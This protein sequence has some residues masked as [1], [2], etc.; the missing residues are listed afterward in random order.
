M[1]KQCYIL[2]LTLLLIS[3][4]AQ[5][6]EKVVS[7]VTLGDYPPFC[8]VDSESQAP[9]MSTLPPGSNVAYF[10]GYSWDVLRESFHIMGYTIQLTVA[11]WPRAIK[12]VEI[13][14]ADILFPTGKNSERLKIFDYSKE[15][16]NEAKFLVYVTKDNP[17]QWNG[18]ESFNNLVIG[19]KRGFNY[20]DKWEAAQKIRRHEVGNIMNGFL[21]LDNK[22]ISGFLGYEFNWDYLLKQ[23]GWHNKYRKLPSFDSSREYLTSLKTNPLGPQLLSDFDKGKQML[24]RN[25]RLEEIQKEWFGSE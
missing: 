8:F 20:G 16:I 24:I 5:S 1:N 6:N 22:R 2:A 3:F 4:T 19:I 14:K 12:Y 17:I 21:M 25:G 23:R 9:I 7:V 11:P 13:G 10:T 18:L 15:F